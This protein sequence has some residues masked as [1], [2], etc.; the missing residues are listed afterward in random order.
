MILQANGKRKKAAVAIVTSDKADFK[1]KKTMR[2]KGRQ[3]IMIKG[4]FHQENIMLSYEILLTQ[5]HQS[6]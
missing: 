1:V 3:Y 6:T 5:E 2:D 4:T